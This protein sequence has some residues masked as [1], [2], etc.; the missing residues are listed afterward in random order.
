[1][2]AV[3]PRIRPMRQAV[4]ALYTREVTMTFAEVIRL[5]QSGQL[6][7]Y[8]VGALVLAGLIDKK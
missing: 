2:I 3:P 8:L 4:F 5:V 1:M 6:A 7:C